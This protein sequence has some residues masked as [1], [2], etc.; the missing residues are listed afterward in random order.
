MKMSDLDQSVKQDVAEGEKKGLYYYVNKRKKAGTSRDA[1]SPK[2]PTA[3]AWKD[4][5]KT[6]KKE[7]VSEMRNRRDAY[8]RDYDSS[9]TGFGRE[10][11]HR[12]L[13]QELA[14]ETNNIAI[15]INGKTWKVVPGKGYAD[16]AEEWKYLRHMKDWAEKKSASSGKKW[17]VHLT[18]AEPT[19]E[20]IANAVMA[21]LPGFLN[22]IGKDSQTIAKIQDQINQ[23]IASAG[24]GN[25][26]VAHLNDAHNLLS[27]MYKNP[28]EEQA[29][30]F[31]QAVQKA[32][33]AGIKETATAGATSAANVGVGAV[34]KNKPPK[35]PKN[36][37]GT[38]KNALDMNA[39][40]LT[41]GS[42]KR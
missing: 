38:A 35:Q 2:A 8:Q 13:G 39:N 10:H 15:A 3:Q 17:T 27:Q 24:A 41:G 12:G 11:D 28:T 16:S 22:T 9:Q 4:A 36:K 40:L 14:H 20:G 19:N 18:G 32:N 21:K 23:R 29:K 33:G 5:A 42:I 34:Y 31:Y 6:A 7:G 30:A 37:D 26:A 25:P 1:S